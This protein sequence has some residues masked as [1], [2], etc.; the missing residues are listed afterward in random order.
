MRRSDASVDDILDKAAT[1]GVTADE[2][3][4]LVT[5]TRELKARRQQE[6]QSLQE[7]LLELEAKQAESKAQPKSDP[8]TT[9]SPK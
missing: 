6:L 5:K 4:I 2:L 3:D 8:G 1:R 7:L 9:A